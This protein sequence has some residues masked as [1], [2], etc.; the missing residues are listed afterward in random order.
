MNQNET[1]SFLEKGLQ[2]L[3]ATLGYELGQVS[4]W[5]FEALDSSEPRLSV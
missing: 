2:H 4:C 3:A 5:N 1:L